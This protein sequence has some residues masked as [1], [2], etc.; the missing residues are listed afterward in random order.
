[1]A[2]DEQSEEEARI[3]EDLAEHEP[4]VQTAGDRV[5]LWVTVAVSMAI[6][7]WLAVHFAK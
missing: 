2:D 6:A 3:A 4:A 7:I 1:M 5:A